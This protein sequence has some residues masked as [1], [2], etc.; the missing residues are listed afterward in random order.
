[1]STTLAMLIYLGTMT[2]S[3]LADRACVDA[4]RSDAASVVSFIAGDQILLNDLTFGIVY[5]S[6]LGCYFEVT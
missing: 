3:V 5:V 1:M 6:V 4:L 2:Y